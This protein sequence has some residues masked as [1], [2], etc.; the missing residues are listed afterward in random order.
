MVQRFAARVA[1]IAGN[2]DRM[3]GTPKSKHHSK[4]DWTD[5]AFVLLES[6]IAG[7]HLLQ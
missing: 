5:Q 2:G 1:E 3:T 4:I 6:D 7:R